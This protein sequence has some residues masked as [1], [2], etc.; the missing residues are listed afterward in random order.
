MSGTKKLTIAW[1]PASSGGL[2]FRG[3]EIALYDYADH[4][5]KILGHKSVICLKKGAFNEPLVLKKFKDR[6]SI[7]V[8]FSN[9]EDLEQKLLDLNVDA[10]YLIRSGKKEEPVLKKIPM[11]IHCVYDM[12]EEYGL[13]TAGVSDSVAKQ[14]GK[15]KF[16]P[17]MVNL[18]A[19][20]DDYRSLLSIP[21]DA[22]VFGRHGGADTWDLPF[23]KEAM[24]QALKDNPKLYFLFAVRPYILYDVIHPRVICLEC[25]ADLKIK[26]KFINTFDALLHA[27]SLGDTFGLSIAEA[28][29]ANKPV[30][31][32]NGGKCQEHLRILGDKCIKYNSKDELY[33][34]LMS[35]DPATTR[36]KNWQAYEEYVPE[37]VMKK[38][39]SVFLQPLHK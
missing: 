22:I 38:F 7:I 20:E 8:E 34:I 6:F 21:K 4:N 17:H 19:G 3:T 28:S 26:R 37:I 23:A 33:R 29:S 35:F 36:T 15:S 39:D 18:E 30:I 12:S 14:F 27:Q 13:V 16:V 25:F 10:C 24:L 11:L 9:T 2:S 1:H 32:W 31:V 5:E